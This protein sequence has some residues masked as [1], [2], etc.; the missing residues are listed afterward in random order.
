MKTLY[1]MAVC[2]PKK[3]KCWLPMLVGDVRMHVLRTAAS[4]CKSVAEHHLTDEWVKATSPGNFFHKSED[5][6]VRAA[7]VTL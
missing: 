1:Y 3:S 7:R 2:K 5:W 6:H 4:E